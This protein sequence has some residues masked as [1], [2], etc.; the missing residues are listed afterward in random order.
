[1]ALTSPVT[2][3]WREKHGWKLRSDLGEEGYFVY[4]KDS[5]RATVEHFMYPDFEG[6]VDPVVRELMKS[7]RERPEGVSTHVHGPKGQLTIRLN[8]TV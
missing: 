3:R 5:L 7:V 2:R 1:M 4:P 8:L 6:D